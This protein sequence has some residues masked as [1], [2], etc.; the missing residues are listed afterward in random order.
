MRIRKW[1]G[2]AE[3]MTLF[4]VVCCDM[5]DKAATGIGIAVLELMFIVSGC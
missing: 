3:Q 4:Y 1:T 5:P 2:W